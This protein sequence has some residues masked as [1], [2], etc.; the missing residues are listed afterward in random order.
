MCQNI[1]QFTKIHFLRVKEKSGNN[2][3][4]DSKNR[5]KWCSRDF[6]GYNEGKK[7]LL[8]YVNLR[9]KINIEIS[10]KSR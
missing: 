1:G 9:L 5:G 10:R 6:L 2:F 4:S 3:L 8:H 7:I